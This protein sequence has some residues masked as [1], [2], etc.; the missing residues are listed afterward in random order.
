MPKIK[1]SVWLSWFSNSFLISA[2][3][4]IHV[5][6][7]QYA[8]DDAY[9]H[10]RVARNLFETGKPYFN[11]NDALKV[12]TSSGWIIFLTTLFGV[13]KT[14]GSES[15]FPLLI[16]ITNALA[17]AVGLYVYT[18]IVGVL[19]QKQLTI[20][21][22]LL[23]QTI[24][25]A[26]LL[27]S[28]IGLMETPLAL[29][30][31]GLGIYLLLLSK[32]SG[33]ALLGLAAYIRLELSILIALTCLIV[34][35]NQQ[36]RFHQIIGYSI[37]GSIP[38]VFFDL[39]FYHTILPH[40]IIA[41]SIVYSLSPL[42]TIIQ[43]VFSS[44]PAIPIQNQNGITGM[45]FSTL[46]IMTNWAAVREKEIFKIF[47]PA[48][49]S[50]LSLGII[51][52]YTIGHSLMFGW[53]TP[54]YM[55]PMLVAC[56]LCSFLIK[57]PKN[58]IVKIPL[59]LLFSLSMISIAGT[60]YAG[61]SNPNTFGLFE[62]GSRVKT[63]LAVGKIIND[64]YPNATLLTSEIGGLGYSFKG[65]IFD[66]AG[67]ASSDA[68]AFHPMKVPEQREHGNIGAIPPEYVKL[69]MPDIIVSYDGFAQALLRDEVINQYSVIV[70][71]AYL[72]EDAMYSE[73]KT[74]WGSKYLRVYIHKSL[75]VSE[76]I[77]SLSIIPN[78]TPTCP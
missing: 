63:Y 67:L 56:F 36:F 8:F 61:I 14:F 43:I 52:I 38:L 16:S 23:F 41:K 66:A 37:L 42:N 74:I 31:A 22:K 17:M 54:L 69:T 48:L 78:E 20:P 2:L 15:Y 73:S 64:E 13:A 29:L 49:F 19:L 44:L 60:F 57:Y 9:I 39:Y 33:F 40:S 1:N 5:R 46:V 62:T 70:I 71:P 77:C 58:I 26:M 34:L 68:L 12:S 32:P 4:T 35:F 47:W 25:V 76:R 10:F 21:Q 55:L 27:P 53:Y 59:F 75:P 72:P 28:S 45:T 50:F 30:I 11:A 3:I 24:F 51:G 7:Y 65:K 18:K 6:L